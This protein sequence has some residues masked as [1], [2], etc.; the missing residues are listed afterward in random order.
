LSELDALESLSQVYNLFENSKDVPGNATGTITYDTATDAVVIST[1]RGFSMGTFAHE[2]KHAFQFQVAQLSFMGNGRS[3]G[4]LYDRSDEYEA[5]ERGGFFG[6]SKENTVQIDQI[7]N[8]YPTGP[9]NLNSSY[10]NGPT[11]KQRFEMGTKTNATRGTA[12]EQFYINWKD[13][14]K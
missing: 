10:Q 12:Q 4:L 13:D 8:N 14:K 5:H 1:G 9:I 2:L 6:G 3:P 11:Y 7:Y